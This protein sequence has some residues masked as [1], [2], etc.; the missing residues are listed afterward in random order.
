M[1]SIDGKEK[2]DALKS[3]MEEKQPSTTQTSSNT[4]PNS[5][6]KQFQ[7]GKA[8]TSSKEGPRQGKSHKTIHPG[9]Q[10]PKDL[11]G[12]HGKCVSDGQNH[13]RILEKG[14]SLIEISDI[15]SEIQDG[16]PNLYIA[17]NDIKSHI[18]DKG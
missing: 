7:H 12:C 14:G 18:S 10:N 4:S 2:N 6:K 16:I 11:T 15:M 5:Q 9:L 17:I 3:R 1:A 8:A 13:D